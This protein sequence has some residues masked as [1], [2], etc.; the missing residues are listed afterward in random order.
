MFSALLLICSAAFVL[1]K[2]LGTPGITAN[3]SI[4]GELYRSIDLHAV[5]VPYDIVIETEFGRN[6]VHV[7]HGAISVTDADCPDLIC[8]HQGRISTD[9]LPIVCLP[10]R[11]VIEIQ[12]GTP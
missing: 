4:D 5:A 7:E 8:V 2:S 1:L 10:H 3:I 9:A 11:L 6:T 12:G